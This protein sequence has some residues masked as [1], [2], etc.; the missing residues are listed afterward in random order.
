MGTPEDVCYVQGSAEQVAFRSLLGVTVPCPTDCNHPDPHC[1]MDISH[2]QCMIA[3]ELSP[4]VL[5][6]TTPLE[7]NQWKNYKRE[8]KGHNI[9]CATAKE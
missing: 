3:K 6:N 8:F 9:I 2:I 7:V 5:Y 4:P 1:L